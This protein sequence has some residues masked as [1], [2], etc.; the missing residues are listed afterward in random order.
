[1]AFKNVRNVGFIIEDLHHFKIETKFKAIISVNTWEHLLSPSIVLKNLY[2]SL[3]NEGILVIIGSQRWHYISIIERILPLS[4]KNLAWRLLKG[5][6]NM[7]YP[8][9][10]YFCSKRILFVEAYRQKYELIHFSS[11]E[12]P[13]IWFAKIP[14]LFIMA[15]LI[16]P[17]L[18][19]YH[20][21]EGI[22]G[23]FIA[24]L[25]KK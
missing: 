16:M 4:I 10:Y 9:F 1:M 11:L 7:P 6:S 12:G 5:R 22:R 3:S 14:P 15:A 2:N 18:N 21:F 13:P 25:R 23:S 20:I 24:V 17:I 8:T 19:R